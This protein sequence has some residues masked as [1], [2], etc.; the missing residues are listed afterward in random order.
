MYLFCNRL[1]NTGSIKFVETGKMGNVFDISNHHRWNGPELMIKAYM[2]CLYFSKGMTKQATL[3]SDAIFCFNVLKNCICDDTVLSIGY[4][5]TL[6]KPKVCIFVHVWSCSKDSSDRFENCILV[7][8]D[9]AL[10]K[11]FHLNYAKL[12]VLC[13][14]C[15][16]K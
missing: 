7:M 9:K 1:L 6:C 11:K 16:S 10:T 3:F 5:S 13:H 14:A 12:G 2:R 4:V 15:Q 8:K